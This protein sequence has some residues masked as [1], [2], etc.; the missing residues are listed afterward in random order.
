MKKIMMFTMRSCPYCKEALRL[1]DD[2]FAEDAGYKSLEIEKVDERALPLIAREYNYYFVP[3]FFVDGKKM[4]E[5]AASLEKIR[6]VFD[7]AMDL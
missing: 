1:M 6:R 4:H 5:G 7:A 2:L 3:A